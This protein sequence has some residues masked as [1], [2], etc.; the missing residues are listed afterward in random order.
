MGL[1]ASIYQQVGQGVKS[2][3]DYDAIAN[4]AQANKLALLLQQHQIAN[5]P[6]QD[7]LLQYQ[8]AGAGIGNEKANALLG[9]SR[10]ILGGETQQPNA[11]AQPSGATSYPVSSG[12][13]PGQAQPGQPA[14]PGTA[15]APTGL[16]GL[17]FPRMVA[18]KTLGGP[19]LSADYKM[20]V[21]GV[22]HAPGSEVTNVVDGSR[23][24]VPVLDKG[25]T[26]G[27]DGTI[28]NIPGFVS[29]SAEAAGALAGATERAKNAQTPLPLGYVDANTNRPVGGTIGAYLAPSQPASSQIPAPI[30]SLN[31]LSP[32]GQ[33]AAAADMAQRGQ[34]MSSMRVNGAPIT[35]DMQAQ[36]DA[37]KQGGP[38]AMQRF[39]ETV[40]PL[41]G[42][43][44][45]K[46]AGLAYDM[47]TPIGTPIHALQASQGGASAPAPSAPVQLAGPADIAG[48]ETNAKNLAE[49]K[50]GIPLALGKDMV[51][52]AHTAN[53]TFVDNLG[54]IVNNE[55]ELVARNNRLQPLL[56]QLPNIG[57]F[58]QDARAD[59]ANKLKNSGLLPQGALDAISTKVAGGD[60]DAA[61]VVQNQLSAAAIQTMLD[62]LNKEGKPNR[63]MFEA[64]HAQQEGLAAGKPVLANIMALQNQLYQQHLGQYKQATDLMA[65][66]EYNP[67]RFGSQFAT[68][69]SQ[70][71]QPGSGAPGAP[72]ATSTPSGIDTS[73][74]AA[75]LKRRGL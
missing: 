17:T 27:S 46:M 3:A 49:V 30:T 72:S 38:A 22:S 36:I 55:G 63:A 18:L 11:L 60:A 25:Q 39:V 41:L 74:I 40:R 68:A 58:S 28:S 62:T 26:L 4:T 7:Q 6:L 53:Q 10:Q 24:T 15:V 8:I 21:E 67:I 51:V 23:R 52:K 48:A 45:M 29:S 1:D 13:S 65:S 75:E 50:T 66:P 37:A 59:F 12:G 2:V 31:Q 5:L 9:L 61:K 32:A 56:D 69:K 14:Q 19:D 57:G 44:P 47:H 64:L 16:G 42:G 34:P 35:G 73:A 71:I 33:Q 43:D 20:A 54:E 70:S